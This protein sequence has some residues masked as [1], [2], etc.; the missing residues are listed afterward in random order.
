MLASSV[1]AALEVALMYLV[2]HLRNLSQSE[3]LCYAGGVALNSVA[4]EK[5]IRESGFKNVYIIPA[6]EDSGTAIGA[7]YYGLWQLTRCN[8]QRRMIDDA[9]G[10]TYSNG[11]CLVGS[12]WNRQPQNG[13]LKRRDCRRC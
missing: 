7:A 9:F 10:R 8:S 1:Q 4:N 3:N 13:F 11:G 5:I 6:A 12:E 2:E